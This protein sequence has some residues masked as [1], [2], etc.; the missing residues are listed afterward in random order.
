MEASL[1][2]RL[3]GVDVADAGDKG[4]IEEQRLDPSPAAGEDRAESL[5]PDLERLGAEAGQ[6][7]AGALRL[8][9]EAEQEAELADVAETDLVA[10]VLEA[11][12]QP[13]VLVARRA[14]GREQE[15]AGH[16][17][18]EDERPRALALDEEHLAPAPDAQNAAAAQGL[19]RLPA[20]RP[21]ER[22]VEQID[23]GDGPA[24]D[25]GLE[26][27]GDGLDFGQ[28]GHAAILPNPGLDLAYRFH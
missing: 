5:G 7:A 23:P 27:A 19:E 22:P 11:D 10:P 3:V 15:L 17:Q 24:L 28:L 1:E 12:H 2:E 20:A 26:R 18:V 25:A 9:L 21:E 8:A 6:L 13:D 14:F 16:L 4:L